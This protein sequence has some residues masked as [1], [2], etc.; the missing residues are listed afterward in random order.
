[1]TEDEAQVDSAEFDAKAALMTFESLERN[2]A[3]AAEHGDMEVAAEYLETFFL[4]TDQMTTFYRQFLEESAAYAG[5]TEEGAEYSKWLNQQIISIREWAVENDHDV[6]AWFERAES[7][8]T[9]D[10]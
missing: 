4:L 5:G 9:G 7:G 3:A 1:M 6:Q 10:Q 8:V 2:A